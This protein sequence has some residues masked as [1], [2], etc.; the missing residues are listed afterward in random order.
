MSSS[1]TLDVLIIGSGIA[2]LSTALSIRDRSVTVIGAEPAQASASALAQGGLAAPIAPDDSEQAHLYDTITAGAGSTSLSAAAAVVGRARSAVEFLQQC[3]V[4]FDR[5]ERG[6]LLHREGGHSRAR[7][8]RCDGD[9]T[10]SG[11]V[12]ALGATALQRSNIDI[13]F[14]WRLIRLL[15]R[16]DRVIGAVLHDGEHAQ[17]VFARDVVLATGGIGQ[18]F[19]YTTNPLIAWGDGLAAALAIGAR[20]AALEF[21]QFHPTALRASC[22]PLPLITEALRG[23][24]ARLVDS[25]GRCFMLLAHPAA[26]LAPRDVVAQAVWREMMRGGTVYLDAMHLA[27]RLAND[28]PTV[29]ALCRKHGVDPMQQPIPITPAVHFHMGG[30]AADLDGRTS[31]Q[32]LWACGEVAHTGLH[33]ANRL[34]SNSLLEAVVCGRLVGQALTAGTEPVHGIAVDIDS[35]DAPPNSNHPLLLQLQE[36]MW[37][38]VGIER[39]AAGLREAMTQLDEMASGL[40]EREGVLRRR[41]QLARAIVTAALMRRTSL[42]AHLRSDA[43]QAA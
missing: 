14:G 23:I 29:A 19:R 9:A 11:I 28:F 33:G 25:H 7:V 41:V 18:L 35:A 40:R 42:G 30:V 15:R 4:Q 43:D 5:D 1:S 2:G 24:G 32:N 20:T 17:P 38:C 16:G 21:V 26:E 12:R 8:L 13:Q 6:F 27:P 39:T 10:G 36:L 34:A 3:G 31:V 37:S 22:N